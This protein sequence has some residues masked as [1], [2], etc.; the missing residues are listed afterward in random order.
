MNKQFI[1][2]MKESIWEWNEDDKTFIHK[3]GYGYRVEKRAQPA[4]IL[5]HMIDFALEQE[6]EIEP[7]HKP[8]E[9]W[10]YVFHFKGKCYME[11]PE[12]IWIKKS[13]DTPGYYEEKYETLQKA[14]QAAFDKFCELIG[15][16][17]D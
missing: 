4:D 14:V 9:S 17:N 6:V 15:V 5:G 12:E 8:Y 16:T 11:L 13:K 1:E 10:G 7:L 3:C 2:F